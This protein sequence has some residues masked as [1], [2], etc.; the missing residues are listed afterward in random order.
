MRTTVV[1]ALM[2]AAGHCRA[3]DA[4]DWVEQAVHAHAGTDAR[5]AK[6]QN[7]VQTARGTVNF[8]GSDVAATREG[9]LNLPDRVRWSFEFSQPGRKLPIILCVNGAKGWR[10]LTGANQDMPPSEV[11][12]IR[13]ESYCFWLATLVPL[14]NKGFTLARLPDDK[15]DGQPAV[16]VKV[17]APGKPDVL[18][19][20]DKVKR[21]LVKAS[22]R[23]HEAGAE[24]TKDYLF[25]NFR[26]FEGLKLP[27]KQVE[28]KDGK[29]AAEWLIEGYK[30]PDKFA[31]SVFTKP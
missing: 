15:V 7:Y 1:L 8:V 24:V 25:S 9:Q 3:D 18:L 20:F 14:G 12:L 31:D 16:V 2:V 28:L 13:E 11:D 19:S 5:L 29:K 26:E 22:F 23:G 27:T 10:S 6:L 21:L 17:S 30:F 4:R